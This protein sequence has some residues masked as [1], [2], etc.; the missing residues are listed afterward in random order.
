MHTATNSSYVEVPRARET[1]D[2]AIVLGQVCV[3]ALCVARTAADL[4]CGSLRP[5]GGIALVLALAVAVALGRKLLRFTMRWA[6]QAHDDQ[7]AV[8]AGAPVI[9]LSRV[10]AAGGGRNAR[11]R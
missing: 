11:V 10:R 4:R 5:E 1:L 2:G 3:L 6:A 8:R 9:D 7:W